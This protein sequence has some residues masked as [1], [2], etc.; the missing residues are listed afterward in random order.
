ML[1]W[2]GCGGVSGVPRLVDD[3]AV[4]LGEDDVAPGDGDGDQQPEQRCGHAGDWA[5]TG[6]SVSLSSVDLLNFYIETFGKP[7]DNC[8]YS[9]SCASGT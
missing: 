8:N 2:Y 6:S 4:A 3:G 1:Q 9:E 7:S 5:L